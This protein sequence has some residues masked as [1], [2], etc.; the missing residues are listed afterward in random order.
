[1]YCS[2]KYLCD[3]PDL[4]TVVPGPY[5]EDTWFE[6]DPRQPLLCYMVSSDGKTVSQD[7]LSDLSEF[8]AHHIRSFR[9]SVNHRIIQSPRTLLHLSKKIPG[10]NPDCVLT[11]SNLLSI[12]HPYPIFGMTT[13]LRLD[14]TN[15]DHDKDK[16]LLFPTVIHSSCW[17][18]QSSVEWARKSFPGCKAAGA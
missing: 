6:S 17:A 16:R 1:V 14:D 5:S 11:L 10:Q 12:K 9:L 8:S 13:R 15:F 3:E 2:E 7:T 4:M 18:H